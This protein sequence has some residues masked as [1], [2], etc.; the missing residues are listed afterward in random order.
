MN[1]ISFRFQRGEPISIVDIID[2]GT[3]LAGHTM[4]ARMKP[5][6]RN[7]LG[8][9]PGEEVPVVSPVFTSVLVPEAGAEKV[10]FIHSLTAAQSLQ[11]SAGR[12]LFDSAMLLDG[13]VQM[14]TDPSIIIIENSA[15]G[16][17]T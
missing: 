15:S 16:S 6:N 10:R 7:N 5:A 11:I 3:L 1:I 17:S 13:V 14:I 12:Y 4:R 8:V 9:M 2:M